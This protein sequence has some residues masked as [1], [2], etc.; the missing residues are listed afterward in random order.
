MYFESRDN[1]ICHLIRCGMTEESKTTP[2][3]LAYTTGRI[4]FPLTGMGEKRQ[5]YFLP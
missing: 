3:F 2:G 4:E 1:S 5:V